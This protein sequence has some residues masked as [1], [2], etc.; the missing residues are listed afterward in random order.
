MTELNLAQRARK[1]T[2]LSQPQFALVLGI[3]QGVVAKWESGR[4]PTGATC[5]LLMLIEEHPELVVET[6]KKKRIKD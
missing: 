1:A 2:G 6:L 5:S 4:R 3:Q